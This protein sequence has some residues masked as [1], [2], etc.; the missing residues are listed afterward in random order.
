MFER[1]KNEMTRENIGKKV[2]PMS[3]DENILFRLFENETKEVNYLSER[4]EN[5]YFMNS[6]EKKDKELKNKIWIAGGGASCHMMNFLKR[7]E[8]VKIEI[9]NIKIGRGKTIQSTNMGSYVGLAIHLKKRKIDMKN[10]KYMPNICCN[11][12]R[13]TNNEKPIQAV[14]KRK[15]IIIDQNGSQ[16]WI[17]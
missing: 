8:D 14:G 13:V 16:I 7:T 6:V 10:V 9:L 4:I 11:L 3:F 12:L 1:E 17:W 15:Q 2:L 5:G